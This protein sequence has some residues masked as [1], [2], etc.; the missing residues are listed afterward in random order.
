MHFLLWQNTFYL[1]FYYVHSVFHIST[2]SIYIIRNCYKEPQK[3]S[4]FVR[5]IY[6]FP[7]ETSKRPVSEPLAV[8]AM[9]KP[10]NE[11][12]PAHPKTKKSLSL[13]HPPLDFDRPI[14]VVAAA[15]LS[16]FQ[17]FLHHFQ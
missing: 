12:H 17:S 5:C 8:K 13:Y 4:V 14:F 16:T 9:K 2:Y 6:P 7:D 1:C 15:K 10:S 3:P 11:Q